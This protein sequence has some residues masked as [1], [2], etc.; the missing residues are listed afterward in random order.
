MIHVLALLAKAGSGKT[1]VANYLRDT[2]DAR[3]VSLATPLKRCAQKVLGFTDE[4]LWGTQ[5]QKE[6][7]SFTNA[8]GAPQ[9]ARQF[10]QLLGTEGLRQEFGPNIHLD[11]LVHQIQKLDDQSENHR[12]YVVDDVRFPNEVSYLVQDENFHG[13]CVKIVCSDLPANDNGAHASEAL[14]DRVPEEQLAATVVSSRLAG[15]DH[16]IAQLE[17]A[18]ARAPKLR[19]FKRVLDEG[20]SKLERVAA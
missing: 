10:L 6:A 18:L 17:G 8:A 20:R 12:V 11:A 2:C 5:E 16:L 15:T 4:Q 13:A 19:R 9:S 7:P 3:V 14:I 1:T